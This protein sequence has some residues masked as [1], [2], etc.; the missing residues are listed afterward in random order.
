MNMSF[1]YFK[2]AVGK[3]FRAADVIGQ[4]DYDKERGLYIAYS[5]SEETTITGNPLSHTV[6]VRCG[7]LVATREI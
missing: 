1:E 3:F 6:T 4:F 2:K 5:L 7:N